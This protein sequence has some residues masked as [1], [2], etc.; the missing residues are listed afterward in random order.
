MQTA[1][2]CTFQHLTLLRTELIFSLKPE[3]HAV[4]LVKGIKLMVEERK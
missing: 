3:Q 4:V 1:L 2:L